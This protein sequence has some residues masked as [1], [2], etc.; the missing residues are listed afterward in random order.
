MSRTLGTTRDGYADARYRPSPAIRWN[1]WWFLL[2]IAPVALLAVLSRAVPVHLPYP[3]ARPLST[4]LVVIVYAWMVATL[5]AASRLRGLRSLEKDFGWA[6]EPVDV[7]IG[8]GAAVL[9]IVLAALIA[10]LG[11]PETNLHLTGDRAWDTIGVFLL[12]TVVAAPVEE[13]LFRGL[14]MRWIRIWLV[15]HR[16]AANPSGAVH[17]SVLL[18]AAVFAAAHL[19]EASTLAGVVNLGLQTLLLGIVAGYL[20][21]R[22]ARLGPAVVT[23][24][25]HNAIVGVLALLSAS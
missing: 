7:A 11:T 23:H 5:I 6:I 2:A 25:V 19:Y 3:V 21:T 18:S 15:R 13:L 1:G 10:P 16:P 8:A 14:L 24:G 20:A 9:L 4:A 22:T 12:P 17:A